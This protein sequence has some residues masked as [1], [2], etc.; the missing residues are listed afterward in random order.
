MVGGADGG[1]G[2]GHER[3]E[4]AVKEADSFIATYG[5]DG[6]GRDALMGKAA[7]LV[8]LGKAKDAV[9]IYERL[10]PGE[11]S[12]DGKLLLQEGLAT[13][14]EASGNLDEAVRLFDQLATDSARSGNFLLD[15]ALFS[16]AR[17]LEKQGKAKDA[18]KALRA[19]LEKS[20][21]TPLRQQV[22]D[23]LALLSEK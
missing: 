18:E 16:K 1:G 14:Q 22:D 21:K 20:P 7:R 10:L 13:A 19:L 17:I 12:P 9:A 6:L 3:L 2:S 11:A 4:A 23:R 8:Q 15:Q 5:E